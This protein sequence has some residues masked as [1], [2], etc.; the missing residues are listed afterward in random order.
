MC[1]MAAPPGM[2]VAPRDT[3]A[4]RSRWLASGGEPCLDRWGTE[5][6]LATVPLPVTSTDYETAAD[7]TETSS[8]FSAQGYLSR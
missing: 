1:P 4:L 7:A 8:Y 3:L 2:S 5:L 6:M